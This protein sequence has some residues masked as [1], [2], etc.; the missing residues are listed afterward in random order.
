MS[1][2]HSDKKRAKAWALGQ[3]AKLA[4]GDEAIR[5]G[6]VSLG[7]V[8]AAFQK[9]RSPRK[10]IGSQKSDERKVKM[11][12]RVLDGRIDPHG[13]SLGQW[14]RFIA[15]RGSGQIDARGEHV[16]PEKLRRVRNR[17][18]EADCKWLN[19]VFNWASKWRMQSGHYL[20]RENS[21]RGLEIPTEKN[22]LRPVATQ[23]RF[24][25]VRAVS[26]QVMMETVG[27]NVRRCVATSPSCS[28]SP[29]GPDGGSP[30]SAS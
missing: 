1:L 17:A 23:D 18:V 21:I 10:S 7:D 28:I 11:W 5:M 29:M 15:M 9:H 19:W 25:A 26:D 20:M 16:E 3:A 4:K 30:P 13:I 6:K 2:G 24:E 8:F 27:E 22:P 14:E 12:T